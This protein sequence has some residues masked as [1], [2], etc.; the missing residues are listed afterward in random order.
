MAGTLRL[1]TAIEIRRGDIKYL[2]H[3][4]PETGMAL[5]CSHQWETHMSML[6]SDEEVEHTRHEAGNLQALQQLDAKTSRDGY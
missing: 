3:P 4:I 1:L 5:Q 2:L 6:I